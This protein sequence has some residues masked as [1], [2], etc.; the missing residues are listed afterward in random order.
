MISLYIIYVKIVKVS[1]SMAMIFIY[2]I[3]STKIPKMGHP[4]LLL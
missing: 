4:N 2:F 1:P 3:D